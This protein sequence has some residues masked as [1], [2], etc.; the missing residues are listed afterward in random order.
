MDKAIDPTIEE[1]PIKKL[2][3]VNLTTEELSALA[4]KMAEDQATLERLEDEKKSVTKDF[5]SRIEITTGTIRQEAGTY[6]QGW[7]LREVQCSEVTDR[8]SGLLT[9]V[10]LDTGEEVSRRK[11]TAE[12]MELR[13]PLDD[14]A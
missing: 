12:E 2:L 1:R 8:R 14:A 13:L 5:A 7:E 11:L 4:A 9:V 3:R 10:R 6:R